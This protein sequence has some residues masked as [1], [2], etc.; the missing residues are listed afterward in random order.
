MEEM[1]GSRTSAIYGYSHLTGGVPGGQ[2]EIV[3]VPFAEFNCLPVPDDV[4]DDKALY[5]SDVIP[6]SYHGVDAAEVKEGDTVAIW[7]LG[8]IG[9]LVARW[10]QIRKAGRIIGIDCVKERLDLAKNVLGIEVINFKKQN[11]MKTLLEW[12]PT[13]VDCTI[14]CA[15]FEYVNPILN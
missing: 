1:Y 8:P 10:C 13:G 9:L 7:G 12:F 3:R 15:G 2:A 4:P 11:T 5:L 14:E 6:T